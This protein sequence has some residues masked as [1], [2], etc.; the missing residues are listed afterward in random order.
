VAGIGDSAPAHR[1][2][3]QR[4]LRILPLLT[5]TRSRLARLLLDAPAAVAFR[6]AE[7][8]G[9]HAGVDAATV[10]R[11]SRQLGYAGF[12]DLKRV[13]QSDVPRVVTATEKIKQTITHDS[14]PEGV[15][16]LVV[17]QD[18]SNLERSAALNEQRT[19]LE[20][21]ELIDKSEMTL[22]LG[23]GIS[24]PIGHLLAH[25]L[26]LIG[27]P[28]IHREAEVPTAVEIAQ[29]TRRRAVVGIAFRRYMRSTVRLFEEAAQRTEATIAITDSKASP[30]EA[31]ARVTLLAPTDAAELTNSI[32]APIS[33]VNA[34]VTGL[35]IVNPS[36]ALG[37]L[38]ELDRVF[39]RTG[40]ASE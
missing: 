20:A 28:A 32:T 12:S 23:G 24:A 11:F 35:T 33:V 3:E 27:V 36:R 1:E 29:L 18:V 4:L 37:H 9:R 14:G 10:V 34:L 38:A 15:L 17:A 7:D 40:I 22:V 6:S 13:L 31:H 26:R 5:P 16:E 21:I 39:Q 30:L 2:F 25:L 19:V 8:L